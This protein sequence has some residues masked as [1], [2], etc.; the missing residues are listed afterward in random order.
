MKSNNRSLFIFV[1]FALVILSL[2]S[3]IAERARGWTIASLAN[4]WG[5]VVDIKLLLSVPF[6]RLGDAADEVK[7]K[8]QEIQRLLLENQQLGNELSHLKETIEQEYGIL[9]QLLEEPNLREA[10][11]KEEISRHQEELLNLFQLQLMNVPAKVIYRPLNTWHSSIWIDKGKADNA[12]LG[13]EVIEHNSPVVL[14][15]SVI[16]VIDYIGENQS[17]V[18]LITDSGLCPSV[19]IKRGDLLL[20]KGE[21]SGES[22][23]LWRS[24]QSLLKGV[25]FNYDFADDEGPARDLRTGAPLEHNSKLPPYPLVQVN[26]LLITTGMDGVF[27]PGLQVATVR[28]IRPLQEGDYTYTL[29]AE[30]TAGNLN[31][32]TVV[33]ILPSQKKP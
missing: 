33:F 16:G 19:R 28:K 12:R 29:E 24:H 25:G 5:T 11:P 27:P 22:Q 23:P 8:D 4:V 9:N 15:T 13:R 7:T 31:S 21:L 32:L 10:I 30:S 3:S 20:A 18:R 1:F 26:D 6:E 17:R 14:G 2:P